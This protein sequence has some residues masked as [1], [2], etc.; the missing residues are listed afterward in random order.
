[1]A[2]EKLSGY[3]QVA[4]GRNLSVMHSEVK[5]NDMQDDK[6]MERLTKITS[7]V[8]DHDDEL[9]ANL[10]KLSMVEQ[11]SPPIYDEKQNSPP[12]YDE[13]PNLNINSLKYVLNDD[14]ITTEM[15]DFTKFDKVFKH[16]VAVSCKE[17]Y[18]KLI[19]L[20]HEYFSTGVLQ[21]LLAMDITDINAHYITQHT[22]DDA[23][24]QRL[25][26]QLLNLMH[27]VAYYVYKNISV[28]IKTDDASYTFDISNVL[29]IDLEHDEYN[30]DKIINKMFTIIHI[31]HFLRC[32]IS[33]DEHAK[34]ILEMCKPHYSRIIDEITSTIP[35]HLLTISGQQALIKE[36]C[37]IKSDVFIKYTKDVDKAMQN[38][39]LDQ[40]KQVAIGEL[41]D[42]IATYYK[43]DI[44]YLLRRNDDALYNFISNIKSHNAIKITDTS[45]D[46]ILKIIEANYAI[47]KI[48]KY[49]ALINEDPTSP[50]NIQK[51]MLYDDADF[52]Q[53][54]DY[55]IME[56][57][58]PKK[59]KL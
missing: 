55:V 26:E 56:S 50:E 18:T 3:M 6:L 2:M 9:I 21:Y 23:L 29:Y 45:T 37:S 15:I 43:N 41:K 38:Y 4:N 13:K 35:K 22:N 7:Q 14:T 32:V 27:S 24:K 17:K 5:H 34:K 10:L 47:D 52:M 59:H 36:I 51:Y 49:F 48:T 33:R 30:V 1:M 46:N 28:S 54:V 25:R 16:D 8:M 53:I 57:E 31:L 11:N 44:T 58:M 42:N 40:M 20:A 19:E 39:K 12:I